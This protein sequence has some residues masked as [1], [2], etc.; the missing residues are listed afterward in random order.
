MNTI[1]TPPARTERGASAA[2]AG[3]AG[4]GMWT[5]T[6]SSATFTWLHTPE[7]GRARGLVVLAPPAGREH[8][9]GYRAL[10]QLAML[11]TGAGYCVA[12]VSY[13]GVG[14]SHALRPG[15]DLLQ[16]WLRNVLDAAQQA[17][18]VCG[19]EE[20]P[21]YGIG[22]RVGAGLLSMLSEH[23][24]HVIAW[25][26]VSGKAFANQWSRLRRATLPEIPTGDGV[27]LMGLWLT[28]AQAEQLA[29]I[30]DPRRLAQLPPG[31]EVYREADQP[32]AKVMYGVESLD[33][34]VHYDVLEDLLRRL[35]RP[36]LVPFTGAG[37]GPARNEF[38]AG[39]GV[40]CAEE[41]VAV[42]PAGYPGILTG[43]VA[44]QVPDRTGGRGPAASP[45]A[46]GRRG[47]ESSP[48]VTAA[49]TADATAQAAGGA[50]APWPGKP[51][52]FFAPGASEPRDGSGL[53]P[54]TARRLAGRG[55]VS[56]RADRDGAGDRAL[57][58]SDR[59]PNPYRYLNA[60]AL[61]EQA[62]WLGERFRTDVVATVL[63]SGAWATLRA[64]REPAGLP[65]QALILINQNEWRMHQGFFDGLRPSYDGDAK[66]RAKST[67][68]AADAAPSGG[69]AAAPAHGGAGSV[70][71]ACRSRCADAAR[72]VLSDAGTWATARLAEGK[73]VAS[74][75]LRHRTPEPVWNLMARN[76]S[77][78][79]PDHVLERA[80]HGRRVVLLVG[81]QDEERYRETTADRAVSRLQRR[82][83][84]IA[85]RY[86]PAVDHSVLSRTA[87]NQIARQLDELFDQWK[88][89]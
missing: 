71:G 67:S 36:G 79:I 49:A 12:R 72:G 17:R 34:R 27:D 59:D 32:R 20:L 89:Q 2:P 86:V 10:R 82:G 30:P 22:Y 87:R 78:S 21:V 52:T 44:G 19:I 9:Q 80:S 76:P 62:R 4:A 65:A 66:L 61:R 33:V 73:Q 84:Q 88:A 54:E 53:W 8:V 57:L 42:D 63:C 48:E 47:A 11:L 13:R 69:R 1:G 5:G 6:G 39:D 40:L 56:L 51:V 16:E 68:A 26:P 58:W 70:H 31:V 28:D 83:R 25:E 85:E 37:R 77:A 50:I 15:D 23:F 75:A 14:D 41:V 64:T 3:T 81:P 74:H 29:R 46:A 45:G 24:D 35:P 7:N 38:L 60:Q 55:V 18:E 43:P